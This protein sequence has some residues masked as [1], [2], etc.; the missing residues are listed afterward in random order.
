MC[1]KSCGNSQNEN[2]GNPSFRKDA[3]ETH[4]WL[5]AMT[6]IKAQYPPELIDY[7]GVDG[8]DMVIEEHNLSEAEAVQLRAL[9]GVNA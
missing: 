6:Q 5:N 9:F 4:G 3:E 2:A 8:L 1:Q 7:M